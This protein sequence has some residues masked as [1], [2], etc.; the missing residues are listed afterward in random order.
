MAIDFNRI[1][2]VLARSRQIVGD[3]API[4]EREDE[5]VRSAQQSVDR[6]KESM[7]LQ[8]LAKLPVDKLRDASDSTIRIETLKKFGFTNMAAIY[9]APESQLRSISGISDSSAHEIKDVARQMHKAISDSIAFGMR[10]DSLSSDDLDLIVSLSNLQKIRQA[11]RG[12]SSQMAPVADDISKNLAL[13]APLNSRLRWFFAGQEKKAQAL[14]AVERLTEIS[15]ESKVLELSN[16]ARGALEIVDAEVVEDVQ[17]DFEAHAS[18]YFSL[19]EDVTNSS[20]I[21]AA[22]RHLNQDLLDEIEAAEFNSSL[23]KATMRKYQIFGGKFALTQ[24]RVILGDEMGLGK[25]LQAISVMAHRKADGAE[26]FLVISPASVL[27]NWIREILDRSDLSV[28]KIHAGGRE[29]ALA[30][31]LATGGVGLTTFDTLKSFG[32]EDEAISDLGID[33]IIVDEAHYI[34]NLN[35]GRARVAQK[36]LQRSPRALFLTGTPMENRVEEFVNLASMLDPEMVKTMDRAM[37]ASGADAFR[38]AVAPI[39]LRRN[40]GEVLKELPELIEVNEYCDWEGVDT[41]FYKSAVDNGNFMA[42]RRAG[43]M[44]LE[45]GV[46]SKMA[47]L[48]EL[49]EDA[50]ESNQKVI[51]FSFFTSVIDELV[52]YLGDRA[53]SPITGSVSSITRQKI[54]DDFQASPE[55]KV[56]IGQ[57]QA[58]GTGLNIQGASVVILCEPQIKPSLEVQAIAR[59][60]RMGQV[61]TVRVHRLV[62][63]N[64]VDEYMQNLLQRKIMEFDEFVRKSELA[65]SSDSAKDMSEESMAQLIIMA[66]RKRLGIEISEG[67]TF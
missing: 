18:D 33:T 15:Q 31:W 42:M 57:I 36:W 29:E 46:T 14:E 52:N 1:R 13:A 61:R 44:A 6:S 45:G 21:T 48:L 62:I 5:L 65:N 3:I 16:A 10:A 40:T 54:V 8:E 19:L 50:F 25:T 22:N 9:H 37:M 27:E 47:R 64:S 32:L 39:Y 20:P 35:T 23:I 49:V 43:F 28:I 59:A 7:V 12:R 2:E 53:V 11:T 41:N 63:P 30:K 51:V 66:E 24:N 34:K 60:H 67:K 58:A 38:K 4:A 55:P 56:L 26:R 17:K